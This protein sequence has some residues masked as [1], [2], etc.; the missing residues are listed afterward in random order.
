MIVEAYKLVYDYNMFTLWSFRS[1]FRPCNRGDKFHKLI[2]VVRGH[3]NDT[4]SC[5][6]QIYMDVEKQI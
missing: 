2:S 1:R 4:F 6:F 5:F 3:H